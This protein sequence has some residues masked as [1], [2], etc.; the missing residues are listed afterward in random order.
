[1]KN[2]LSIINGL[3]KKEIY[4]YALLL[5]DDGLILIHDKLPQTY[6]V[7]FNRLTADG[8]RALESIRNKTIWDKIKDRTGL[9]PKDITAL[10]VKFLSSIF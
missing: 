4:Y 2:L 6:N 5:E 1:M 10:A 9:Q 7:A 3:S 8:Y